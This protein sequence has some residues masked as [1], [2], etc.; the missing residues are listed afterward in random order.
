M[1]AIGSP[2]TTKPVADTPRPSP[3]AS[4]LLERAR[5][6][7]PIIREHAGGMERN[8]RV[9]KEVFAALN[10]AGLQ[11][12]LAP[13]SLGG[14]EVNPATCFRV[15]EEVARADSAAGWALQSG[16]LNAYIAARYPEEGIEEIYHGN[17]SSVLC[18]GAFHPPQQAVE[19]EGGYRLTGRVPLASMISDTDWMTFSAFIME[20]G[21]PRMTP[22]GPEMIGVT[23]ATNELQVIDTWYT[24]GMRGTDSNDATFTNVFV[25]GRRAF[26]FTPEYERGRHFRGPLYRFPLI[27]IVTLFSTAVLLATARNAIE[28][29][30]KIA[31]GKVP[32]G[33][34]KTLRDRGTAQAGLADAE[35]RLRA[36][37]AFLLETLDAAWVR[38]VSGEA[39]SIEQRADLLISGVH[40]GRTAADVCNSM[41]AL[42]GTTGIYAGSPLER[43]FRDA[44]TLRNH[45]FV[46]ESKLESAGQAYLGLEPEFP[47]MVF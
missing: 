46:S 30:R 44:H 20:N 35:A 23:I 38:T 18:S 42:A 14:L 33:S 19:V 47:L 28:E 34:M 4:A 27:G 31:Q 11:A 17:A 29:F 37:R 40:A 7:S 22:M 45:A 10:K 6:I 43:Y 9:S 36:A 13:K 5:A 1:T 39:H 3:D 41:Q 15:V 24:L 32:M 21:Q 8:R 2:G 26:L 12:L 25:P 16:N